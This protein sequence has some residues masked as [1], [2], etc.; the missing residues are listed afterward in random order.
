[1]ASEEKW[2]EISM[3]FEVRANFPNCIGTVDGKHVRIIKLIKS[4]SLYFN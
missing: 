2:D 1:M 3:E 4:G